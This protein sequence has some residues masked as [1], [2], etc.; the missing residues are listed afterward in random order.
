[1]TKK[2]CRKARFF[3]RMDRSC[4]HIYTLLQ[5]L[6]VDRTGS[7]SNRISVCS[8]EISYRQGVDAVGSCSVMSCVVKY[9][10]RITLL[11]QKSDALS[12]VSREPSVT[13]III[14]WTLSPSS[15]YFASKSGISIW[16]GPHQLAQ[17]FIITG[18]P[19]KSDRRT[20]LPFMS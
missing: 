17:K 20:S 16:H 2:R 1:M 15:R 13:F 19:A 6:F 5:D 8:Y 3:R 4:D 9:R 18:L 11:G 14:N 7:L 10:K 12:T